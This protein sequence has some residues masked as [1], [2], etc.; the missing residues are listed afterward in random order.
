[1]VVT[2][3]LLATYYTLLTVLNHLNGNAPGLLDVSFLHQDPEII[4]VLELAV[5]IMLKFDQVIFYNI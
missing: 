5:F 1:M 2:E 3:D 4:K